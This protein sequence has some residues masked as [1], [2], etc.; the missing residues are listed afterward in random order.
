MLYG[1]WDVICS[2]GHIDRVTGVT[3]NHDCDECSEKSVDEGRAAVVCPNCRHADS[4][5]G[6]TAQHNC[7]KC[8]A[9]VGLSW[10]G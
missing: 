5:D 9:Q 6:E 8:G 4:V 10:R 3:N 2:N 7:S 1:D